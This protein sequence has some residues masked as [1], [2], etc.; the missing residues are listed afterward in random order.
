[1]FLL[2]C[3]SRCLPR[4]LVQHASLAKSMAAHLENHGACS[5]QQ[6]DNTESCGGAVCGSVVGLLSG[7]GHERRAGGDT[8]TSTGSRKDHEV[9]IDKDLSTLAEGKL[10]NAFNLLAVLELAVA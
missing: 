4:E 9:S 6:T 3:S 10:S 8:G 1:M 5:Q 7:N 2:H